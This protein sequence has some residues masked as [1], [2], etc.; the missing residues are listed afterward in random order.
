[1]LRLTAAV[2]ALV[3]VLL[4][5]GTVSAHARLLVSVPANGAL[6]SAPPAQVQLVFSEPV[7]AAGGGIAVLAPSGRR[8]EQGAAR[9]AGDR[10]AIAVAASEP[11][12]YLV[13]WQVF[14][15]DTHPERGRFTFSV[16]APSAGSAAMLAAGG[17]G[18]VTI[19][20]LLMQVTARGLHFAGYALG[21]GP[22][23]FILLVWQP[24]DGRDDDDREVQR[25]LWRLSGAGVL[26]MLLAEPLALA[27]QVASLRGTPFD[28]TIAGDALASSYGRVL[29]QRL[30]AA[31]ALWVLGVAREEGAAAARW[32]PR[33]ALGVGLFV[34]LIDGEASHAAGTSPALV[35][36]LAN[37]THLVAMAIWLGGLAALLALWH[38]P[39]PAGVCGELARR[40]GRIA[41]VAVLVLLAS[42]LLLAVEHVAGLGGLLDTGYGRSLL[43][44]LALVLAAL[45]FAL[46]GRRALPA[47]PVRWWRGEGATLVGVLA[48]AGL[49]VSLPPR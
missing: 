19:T 10:L 25:R 18:S 34:A 32:A 14:S 48:L 24:L 8:V 21:F 26:L 27:G 45:A 30:G 38:S 43:A 47:V 39:L 41:A 6:L 40:F 7:Q 1:M 9:V 23:A 11:G 36:C 3:F 37:A 31:V 44:K 33:L 13:V 4:R 29:A 12:T 49:L 5:S 35:A 15:Y 16:G 46:A 2:L 42:G 17:S 22:L 28:A 20:G